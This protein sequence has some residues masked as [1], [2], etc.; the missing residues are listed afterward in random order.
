MQID[1]L[2]LFLHIVDSGSLSA[3]ARLCHLSQPAAS[4]NLRILEEGLGVPLFE[5]QGRGLVLTPAGRALVPQARAILAGVRDAARAVGKAAERGYY[6]LRVGAV[7]SIAS[8]IVP[9]QVAPMRARFPELQWKLRTAR[10]AQLLDLVGTGE[11]DIALVAWSGPPPGD[12]VVRLGPYHME[13]FGRSDLFPALTEVSEPSGLDGFPIVEIASLPGQPTRIV[14]DAPTW[15][16][17]NSLASV[18]SLV[19][20]GF[21]VGAMLRFMLSDA[22]AATLTSANLP[23]DPDCAV[24]AVCGPERNDP[25][26]REVEATLLAGLARELGADGRPSGLDALS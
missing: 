19:L 17:A 20:A 21:G 6:D 26:A 8:W 15:A 7:D 13:F 10:S 2:T 22:E 1:H 24:F 16:V 5:R 11:L 12:R 23:A 14:E 4:R 3:A 9:R 18:K 25:R